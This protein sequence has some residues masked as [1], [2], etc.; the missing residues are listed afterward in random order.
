MVTH[1]SHSNRTGFLDLV[2]DIHRLVCSEL[3]ATSRPSLLALAQV[4]P[5]LNAIATSY[6]FRNL[7]LSD[8]QK[9]RMGKPRK[10]QAYEK[11]LQR[12]QGET[13]ERLLR[14]VWHICVVD[15]GSTTVLEAILEKCLYLKK[16]QVFPS[17]PWYCCGLSHP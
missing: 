16:V 14:H 7:I 2:D 8:W 15:M 11:L 9:E 6:I 3:Y 13:G 12:L 5:S 17:H 4:S 10:R 1:E